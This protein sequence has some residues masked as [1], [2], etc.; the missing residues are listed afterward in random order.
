M[1]CVFS[2]PPAVY[3]GTLNSIASIPGPSILTFHCGTLLWWPLFTK[4]PHTVPGIQ[5]DRFGMAFTWIWLKF[6][7]CQ[8]EENFNIYK[9]ARNRVTAEVRKAKYEYEKNL[10]AKIKTD[11]KIFWSY[12][13]KQ[14]K[15]KTVVSKLQMPNGELSST[16]QETANTL[17][18]YFA[19][20]FKKENLDNIPNFDDRPFNQTIETVN[21]TKEL[22]E[23]AI[24]MVNPTKSQ[25]PD[26]IHPRF[27]EQTKDNI[28]E[29]L[30]KIFK[31]SMADSKIPDI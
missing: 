5:Y 20:V 22:V 27:I 23:K 29:P 7:H 28:I 1:F 12:V 9:T 17:N 8:T 11:N 2:F 21:I 24:K 14:T 6:K 19:S 18:N 25:G 30:T 13:R 4:N 31:K 15:T 26:K 16:S 3:V 10:S